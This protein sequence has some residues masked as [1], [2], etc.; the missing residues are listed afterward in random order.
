MELLLLLIFIE[1]VETPVFRLFCV[2]A[3]MMPFLFNG[4]VRYLHDDAEYI[5]P[6]YITI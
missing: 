1:W 6:N 2:H 5:L 4:R 3:F